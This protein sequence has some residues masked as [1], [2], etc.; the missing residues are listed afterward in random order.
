[1]CFC[2]RFTDKE[3]RSCG[4]NKTASGSDMYI[5]Y[6]DMRNVRWPEAE[7]D[8]NFFVEHFSQTFDLLTF[9]QLN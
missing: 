8:C 9:A 4:K 7:V 5:Q 3:L 1:M 6:P 2:L